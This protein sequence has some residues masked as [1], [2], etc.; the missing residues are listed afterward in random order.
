MEA[1]MQEDNFF[2]EMIAE[3]PKANIPVEGLAAYLFQGENQQIIFMSFQRDAQVPEHFHV[4]QWGVVL[5]GGS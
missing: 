3:L 2:P 4:A 1:K 5:D